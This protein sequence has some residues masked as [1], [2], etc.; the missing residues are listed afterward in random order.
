VLVV[1]VPCD[2]ALLPLPLAIETSSPRRCS[3]CEFTAML[4]L[5]LPLA[6][7]VVSCCAAQSCVDRGDHRGRGVQAAR[8]TLMGLFD[9]AR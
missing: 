1:V 2:S 9:A 5:P 7:C 8:F 6:D 4:S 3:L